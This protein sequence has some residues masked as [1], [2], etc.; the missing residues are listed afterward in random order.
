MTES[1]VFGQVLGGT[2]PSWTFA[3]GGARGNE[4]Y[5]LPC[6]TQARFGDWI[7]D[8]ESPRKLHKFPLAWSKETLYSENDKRV[9][10]YNSYEIICYSTGG[11]AWHRQGLFEADMFEVSLIEDRL[12]C[13]GA[14]DWLD[15]NRD[16]ELVISAQDGK[17]IGGDEEAVALY[18]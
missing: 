14:L 9:F 15:S 3:I 16:F 11:I 17:V 1:T 5:E 13:R 7:V 10:V 4:T 8:I 6:G 12:L 2:T 18:Q